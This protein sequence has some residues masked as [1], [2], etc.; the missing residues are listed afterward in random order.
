MQKY[1]LEIEFK[2]PMNNI[3]WLPIFIESD[4]LNESKETTQRIKTAFE[5]H[6]SIIRISEPKQY[7]IGLN[8]DFLDEYIQNRFS[9]K[10]ELLE[11]DVWKIKDIETSPD[12]NFN[13]NIDLVDLEKKISESD[14]EIANT[15]ARHQFPV[16]VIR[17]NQD[18]PEFKEFLLVNVVAP[19]FINKL[20]G[21]FKNRRI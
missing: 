7:I 5:E 11:L 4:N 8:S 3:Y 16:S 6:Y 12:V 21:A 1:F 15:I 14:M 2:T 9:G 18:S 17:Q 19:R 20:V 10:V 13:A